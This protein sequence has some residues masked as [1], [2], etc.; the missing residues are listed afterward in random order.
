MS[1]SMA[2]RS[3]MKRSVCK[4][5]A[6]LANHILQPITKT[7]ANELTNTKLSTTS[8]YEHQQEA[9]LAVEFIH[10]GRDAKQ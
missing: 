2:L 1:K 9:T 10:L 5:T 7:S 3:V 8:H 6:H 4:H